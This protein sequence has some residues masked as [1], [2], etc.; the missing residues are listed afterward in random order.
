MVRN[1]LGAGL[2]QN[3]YDIALYIKDIVILCPVIVKPIFICFF[4]VQEND[5]IIFL[6]LAQQG[7]VHHMILGC[8]PIYRF[9]G[10]NSIRIVGIR[11]RITIMRYRRQSSPVLPGKGETI[12]VGEGVAD[13]IVGDGLAVKAGQ[14]VFPAC[15]RVAVGS[16]LPFRWTPCWSVQNLYSRPN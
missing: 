4:I 5:G 15:I 9:A 11:N 13:L 14:Q 10:A 16:P 6:G 12:A 1:N 2:I 8:R 3:P 7:A